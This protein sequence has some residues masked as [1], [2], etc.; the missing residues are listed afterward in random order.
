[1]EE[2]QDWL[3]D[4]RYS[5]SLVEGKH[6]PMKLIPLPP[7]QGCLTDEFFSSLELSAKSVLTQPLGIYF[8]SRF[9]DDVC[10]EERWRHDVFVQASEVARGEGDSFALLGELVS[11]AK[12][13]AAS[14]HL[15]QDLVGQ[16][17]KE[18]GQVLNREP[19]AVGQAASKYAANKE[20]TSNVSET[21]VIESASASSPSTT[22]GLLTR[23]SMSILEVVTP[24]LDF[25]TPGYAGS[26]D[27]ALF[28]RFLKTA[29]SVGARALRSWESSNSSTEMFSHVS[30]GSVLSTSST[31]LHNVLPDGHIKGGNAPVMRTL[32]RTQR[33]LLGDKLVGKSNA[34]KRAPIHWLDKYIETLWWSRMPIRRDDMAI[35]RDIGRG[36][37]GIVSGVTCVYT[38]KMFALKAMDR[39]LIKGK[40]EGV[41]LLN[42]ATRFERC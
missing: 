17:I 9:I 19:P 38:G 4:A 36:A 7:A 31:G 11:N 15:P 16:F 30:M 10:P 35:F 34:D 25:V 37:F 26:K 1:M 21:K 42:T 22:D 23:T 27:S 39:K 40:R 6:K 14:G 28:R 24:L 12:M 5:A 20:E 13:H 8:M 29:G 18:A 33:Y 2:L 3:A 41:K 32:S